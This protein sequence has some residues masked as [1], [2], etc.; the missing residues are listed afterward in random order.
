M[1]KVF[2]VHSYTLFASHIC[3]ALPCFLD[4]HFKRLLWAWSFRS[5]MLCHEKFLRSFQIKKYTRQTHLPIK[6]KTFT[7]CYRHE[8][9][10]F[11]D[12]WWVG[13][14]MRWCRNWAW[15][16]I[17]FKNS[18]SNNFFNIF[19]LKLFRLITGF[20]VFTVART[21]CLRGNWSSLPEGSWIHCYWRWIWMLWCS[22]DWEIFD[23]FRLCRG[24]PTSSIRNERF[25]LKVRFR[26][27]PSFTS[28]VHIEWKIWFIHAHHMLL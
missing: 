14:Q 20:Y 8:L 15:D 17:G 24:I 13:W 25:L 4:L 12:Q 18:S 7:T 16:E 21:R 3:S 6:K 10:E 26:L 11:G 2:F 9:S 27:N 5:I 28:V 22:G 19:D 23:D 1:T